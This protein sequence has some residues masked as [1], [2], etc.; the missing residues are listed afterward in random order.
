MPQDQRRDDER[1]YHKFTLRELTKRAPFLNWT[2]YFDEAYD[3]H[4]RTTITFASKIKSRVG[5][6]STGMI[7]ENGN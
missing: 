7:N 1:M 2:K 5:K 4:S 6:L 3:Y